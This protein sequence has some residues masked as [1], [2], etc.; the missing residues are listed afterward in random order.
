[1]PY[2]RIKNEWST[3]YV[4]VESTLHLDEWPMC[5]W[6]LWFMC[7][8]PQYIIYMTLLSLALAH[9]TPW[10][11]WVMLRSSNWLPKSYIRQGKQFIS[12][13]Q[14][15]HAIS[16]WRCRIWYSWGGDVKSKYLNNSTVFFLAL[17][18]K[19]F[20]HYS[21]TLTFH[22]GKNVEVYVLDT[23]QIYNPSIRLD[24]KINRQEKTHI[25]STTNTNKFQVE[26]YNQVVWVQWIF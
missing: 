21:L 13:A 8:T 2:A 24:S 5:P 26:V 22:W 9:R 19:A 23:T 1:M 3:S 20:K 15:I 7:V 14:L 17:G 12:E 18:W 25:C 6:T 16:K 10:L 11:S 4:V